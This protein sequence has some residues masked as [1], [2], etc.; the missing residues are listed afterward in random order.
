MLLS[1]REREKKLS[2]YFFK[3]ITC[4]IHFFFIIDQ[5]QREKKLFLISSIEVGC[6]SVLPWF[7]QLLLELLFFII[8]LAVISIWRLPVD[9][10][11]I[12]AQKKR[13]ENDGESS[14]LEDQ[15]SEKG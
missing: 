14:C 10:V 11:R 7:T 8:K 3:V 5:R 1:E 4:L 13:D 12:Q 6:E 2:Y 9:E 15:D